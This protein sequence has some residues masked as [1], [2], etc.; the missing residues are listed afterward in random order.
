MSSVQSIPCDYCSGRLNYGRDGCDL[1]TCTCGAS[2]MRL[3]KWPFGK[4]IPFSHDFIMC[5]PPWQF[6]LRSA[7]G[8]AKSAQAQYACMSL[9]D[10]KALPVAH[11]AAP[12]SILFLW[13]TFAMLPQAFDVMHAWGFPYKTGG[14]AVAPWRTGQSKNLEERA[15]LDHWRRP[16]TQPQAR[17]VLRLGGTVSARRSP[18]RIVQQA[19]P[20]GMVLLGIRAGQIQR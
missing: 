3:T 17:G 12:D 11:L 15:Q 14:G 5:D 8:E 19:A 7:K 10:I 2:I 18:C 1:C 16:R 9:D 6:Q 13:A 20:A 4:L